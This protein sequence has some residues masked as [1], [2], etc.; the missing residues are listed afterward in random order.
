MALNQGYLY[1]GFNHGLQVWGHAEIAAASIEL[2]GE[3][4]SQA[5]HTSSVPIDINFVG[6]WA[7]VYVLS[8]VSI[9]G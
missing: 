8:T 3:E 2:D 5:K 6:L 7:S 1:V 9:V 4:G